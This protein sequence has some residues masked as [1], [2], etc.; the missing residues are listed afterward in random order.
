MVKA[1]LME[2]DKKNLKHMTRHKMKPW[3]KKLKK[4]NCK[5]DVN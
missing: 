3:T 2:N 5:Y 4:K 1:P